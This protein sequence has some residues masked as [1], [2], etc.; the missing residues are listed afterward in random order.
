MLPPHVL[1]LADM[2]LCKVAEPNKKKD[3]WNRELNPG[4]RDSDAVAAGDLEVSEVVV[5]LLEPGA[6]ATAAA[7]LLLHGRLLPCC[8]RCP[9]AFAPLLH[10]LMLHLLMLHSLLVL[11]LLLMFHLLP[12]CI[13]FHVLSRCLCVALHSSPHALSCEC[14][15]HRSTGSWS[16]FRLMQVSSATCAYPTYL[17]SSNAKTITAFCWNRINRF[18]VFPR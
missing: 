18:Q 15:Q 4:G 2:V 1:C 7:V 14:V 12:C 8:I 13:C 16:S 17:S 9:V 10:L 5:Q 6:T 11:H 3:A